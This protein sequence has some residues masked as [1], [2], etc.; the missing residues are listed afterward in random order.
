MIVVIKSY[1]K[2]TCNDM[3]GGEI[4]EF[5]VSVFVHI[6]ILSVLFRIFQTDRK[7][8]KIGK[9]ETCLLT[10]LGIIRNHAGFDVIA[11]GFVCAAI[12]E[13][14]NFL[15]SGLS[16]LGGGDIRL[17][18]A[19]GCLLGMDGGL[20]ALLI[21]GIPALFAAGV[22]CIWKKREFSGLELP[23]GPFLTLG[24]AVMMV[25]DTLNGVS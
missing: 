24:I 25:A 22:Y 17:M 5:Y 11:G 1:I 9:L 21:G 14:V 23:Y 4:K 18:F 7:E 10:V 3:E 8:R 16:G 2:R 12:P 15:V 20:M 13:T 19:A 6:L